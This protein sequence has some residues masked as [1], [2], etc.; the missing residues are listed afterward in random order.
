VRSKGSGSGDRDIAAHAMTP[1]EI[2]LATLPAAVQTHLSILMAVRLR[3]LP[4]RA[5]L[6]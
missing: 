6:T 2:V 4:S 3:L 1:L 5:L